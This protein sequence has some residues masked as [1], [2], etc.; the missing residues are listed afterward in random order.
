MQADLRRLADAVIIVGFRHFS[1]LRSDSSKL[2][3]CTYLWARDAQLLLDFAPRGHAAHRCHRS[4]FVDDV[5]GEEDEDEDNDAEQYQEKI[6][7]LTLWN[8]F[9]RIDH[10]N[11]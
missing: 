11:G 10:K 8:A 3:Y 7:A 4:L 2:L 9:T 5:E 6:N 1:R